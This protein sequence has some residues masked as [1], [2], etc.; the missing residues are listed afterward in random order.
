MRF[1]TRDFQPVQR[2]TRL[3]AVRIHQRGGKLPSER[4][5]ARWA[6]LPVEGSKAWR[7][8]QPILSRLLGLGR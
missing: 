7:D 5:G 8:R 1:T 6:A 2:L 3:P 4:Y